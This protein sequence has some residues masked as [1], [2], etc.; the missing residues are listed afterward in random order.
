MNYLIVNENCT[1]K[2]KTYTGNVSINPAT[3]LLCDNIKIQGK[4]A[5]KV[6]GF[7]VSNA[8]NGSITAATGLGVINGNSQKVKCDNMPIILENAESAI[9]TLTGT[10]PS[11]PPPSAIF[12]DT[13]IINNAGQMK[14]KGE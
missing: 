10:N 8:S 6:I 3:S 4:K 12:T 11:P 2:L 5:Y 13:V 9:I 14:V 7:T 1:L